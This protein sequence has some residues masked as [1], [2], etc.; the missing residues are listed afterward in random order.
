MYFSLWKYVLNYKD[1]CYFSFFN[2]SL[3]FFMINVYLDNNHSALK[4]LKNTE[5]NICITIDAS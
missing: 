5:A 4:Y 3:V 1:I 2:N